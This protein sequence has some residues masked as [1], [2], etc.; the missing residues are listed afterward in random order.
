MRKC[1]RVLDMFIILI[2]VL[3]SQK[4]TYIKLEQFIHLNMYMGGFFFFWYFNYISINL[5]KKNTGARSARLSI[6]K[7]EKVKQNENKDPIVWGLEK[8]C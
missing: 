2:V 4:Y 5:L 8:K 1:F 7:M 6:V 3:V